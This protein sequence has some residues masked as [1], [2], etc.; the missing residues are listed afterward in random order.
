MLRYHLPICSIKRLS[1][2]AS[3]S[4]GTEEN[5]WILRL[6]MR[7]LWMRGTL[8]AICLMTIILIV[9]YYYKRKAIFKSYMMLSSQMDDSSAKGSSNNISNNAVHN[10]NNNNNNNETKEMWTKKINSTLQHLVFST[11]LG[12]FQG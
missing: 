12:I 2:N 7:L 6:I 10:N 4:A 3:L 11:V 9:Q 1:I 5:Y 8:F